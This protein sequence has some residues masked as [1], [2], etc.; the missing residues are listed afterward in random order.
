MAPV[1][2]YIKQK[3]SAEFFAVNAITHKPLYVAWLNFAGT[4]TLTTS[5]KLLI[6]YQRHRSKILCVFCLYYILRQYRARN[7]LVLVSLFARLNWQLVCHFFSANHLSYHEQQP[8]ER[9]WIS[10]SQTKDQGHGTGFF[11]TARH[12]KRLL[13]GLEKKIMWTNWPVIFREGYIWQNPS[14]HI[15][16]SPPSDTVL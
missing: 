13:S 10:R 12:G 2:Q 5:R 6:E 14:R 4:R 7:I 8:L 11:T 15:F 3:P 16:P 9:Y 1:I